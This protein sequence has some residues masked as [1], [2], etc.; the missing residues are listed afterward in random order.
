M[1][2]NTTNTN[3]TVTVTVNVNLGGFKTYMKERE[4]DKGD[5]DKTVELISV[6]FKVDKVSKTEYEKDPPLTD[7]QASALGRS[8][9]LRQAAYEAAVARSRGVGSAYVP[10]SEG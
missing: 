1:N 7:E 6:S 9:G 5:W 2:N 8:E 4:I 3:S 10:T